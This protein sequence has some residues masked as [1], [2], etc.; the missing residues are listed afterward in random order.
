M[1]DLGDLYQELILDHQR[2]PRNFRLVEPHD[3]AVRGHNPLCGDEL[4]L[5]LKLD[6]G[7]VADVGFQGT[8]CAISKASASMM[9]ERIKGRTIEEAID[10]FRRF[11]HML[12]VADASEEDQEVLGKLAVFGGVREFPAR[13]KCATLAWQTLK[14]ALEGDGRTVSTE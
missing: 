13:V 4:V 8:G 11:H 6:Q 10:V 5:Y 1:S 9:T 14:T 3:R 2:R 7:K 12:T